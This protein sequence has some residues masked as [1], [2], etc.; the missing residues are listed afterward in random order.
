MFHKQLLI[1]VEVCIRQST[2][3]FL[4]NVVVRHSNILQRE[5]SKMSL[6]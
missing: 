2:V 3:V 5:L 1:A 4:S 6:H